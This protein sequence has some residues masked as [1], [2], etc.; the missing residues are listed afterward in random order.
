MDMNKGMFGKFYLL[1]FV[2]ILL[3]SSGCRTTYYAAMQKFGYEK[4]H[5]LKDNVEEA[6]DEQK[7][8][9]EQFK[10]ALTRLKEL[11]NVDGGELEKTYDRLKSDFDRS[12]SR[13]TAVRERVGKV[14]TVATD[15]FREWEK[16]IAD[17]ES[18]KLASQSREKLR[19]TREKYESLHTA[20]KRAESSMEPVLAQFR[21]QV[22]YLK[23]NLNAQAIGALRGETMDIEKE[24][25]QLIKDMNASIAQADSFIQGLE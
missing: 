4:R 13:A 3:V 20:M 22:L 6:R 5:I 14:E 8:A 16:E 9:T 11:Y 19:G 24:I 7:K 15:L 2:A 18:A 17:M 10:D 23:H 25:Q 12:E 21:D 1:G